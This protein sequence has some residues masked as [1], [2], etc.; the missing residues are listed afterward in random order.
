MD[1]E[2][3]YVIVGFPK[4]GQ[5]SLEKYF[6]DQ[7]YDIQR[8]DCIWNSNSLQE[9]KDQN[10]GRIPIII[11][12]DPIDMIWDSYWYWH[13][14][15][16][17]SFPEYLTYSTERESN[18]GHENPIDHAD[19]EKHILKFAELNPILFKFNEMIRIPG[20]PHVNQTD[21][22]PQITPEYRKMI[23]KALESGKSTREPL[24][25]N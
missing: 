9:I 8:N 21:N 16:L 3:K 2:S 20:Y 18:L 1:F 25:T 7:G 12:R 11:T 15:S 10:P 19:Y 13:Y 17:M 6:K 23:E 24:F 5:M 4:C 22:K 14:K